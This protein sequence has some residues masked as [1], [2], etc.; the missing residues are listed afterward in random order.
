[1]RRPTDAT[2]HA[3]ASPANAKSDKNDPLSTPLSHP[4][5]PHD[6]VPLAEH[7]AR[8]GEFSKL[9]L[10]ELIRRFRQSGVL[11]RSTVVDFCEHGFHLLKDSYLQRDIERLEQWGMT[12][13]AMA[14]GVMAIS[15]APALDGLFARLGDKKTR[16]REREALLSAIPILNKIAG[17]LEA[18]G[19]LHG[20]ATMS[21]SYVVSALK[22]NADLLIFADTV[23]EVLD[24]NS[25]F[26]VARYAL[27]GAVMRVTGKYKDREVSALTSLALERPN[28][29]ETTHRVWRTRNYAR[30]DASVPGAALALQA[31]N[32]IFTTKLTTARSNPEVSVTG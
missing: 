5:I 15:F 20:K 19:K 25:M 26:E 13:E 7:I 9:S 14:M 16:L 28:Y 17:T 24:T 12:K 2:K 22:A 21:P 30:L 6:P 31:V 10:K 27:A 1:M 18:G 4:T 8:I 23:Y 3:T 29:D 11:S 32:V